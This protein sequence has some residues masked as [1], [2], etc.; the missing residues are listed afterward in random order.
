MFAYFVVEGYI[1]KLGTIVQ[2]RRELAEFS[3]QT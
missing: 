3:I 2:T 1:R